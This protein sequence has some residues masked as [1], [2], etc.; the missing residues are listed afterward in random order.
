MIIQETSPNHAISITFIYCFCC[1]FNCPPTLD[2]DSNQTNFTS[3]RLGWRNLLAK[4]FDPFYLL[5]FVQLNTAPV[6]GGCFNPS[7]L[8]TY[9]IV[10]HHTLKPL[11]SS[12]Y[13]AAR[14]VNLSTACIALNSRADIAVTICFPYCAVYSKSI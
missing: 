7:P 9:V 3:T 11:K 2:A 12:P 1:L 6:A 4:L 13:G 14:L 8:R 10:S 5:F